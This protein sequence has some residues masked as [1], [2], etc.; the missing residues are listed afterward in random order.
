MRCALACAA[1]PA[2]AADVLGAVDPETL[3]PT[4][5]LPSRPAGA[6]GAPADVGAWAELRDLQ[7]VGAAAGI[8]DNSS[9]AGAGPQGQASTAGR[10]GE[11]SASAKGAEGSKAAGAG[12]GGGGQ[13]TAPL[14]RAALTAGPLQVRQTTSCETLL[15]FMTNHQMSNTVLRVWWALDMLRHGCMP[16]AHCA[17]FL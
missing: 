5:D 16:A 17:L 2:H 7:L 13:E 11:A 6:L 9:A 10:K 14:Y 8:E 15:L 4:P 12:V 3:S 1:A